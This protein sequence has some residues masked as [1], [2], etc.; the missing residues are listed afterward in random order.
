M[1]ANISTDKKTYSKYNYYILCC[2]LLQN[3]LLLALVHQY[4]TLTFYM[5]D[6]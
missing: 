3:F 4:P 5:L 2:I 6:F 1:A